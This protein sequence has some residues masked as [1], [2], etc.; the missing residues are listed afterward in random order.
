MK[1]IAVAVFFT[2]FAVGAVSACPKHILSRAAV[3]AA[4]GSA[5][6]A[7]GGAK[8]AKAVARVGYEAAKVI[9]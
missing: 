6:I 2:L 5:Q 8:A 4:K 1:R 7:K 9:F 3:K